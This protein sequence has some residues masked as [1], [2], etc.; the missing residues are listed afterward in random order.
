MS[1]YETFVNW[2]NDNDAILSNLSLETYK[3]S[4]R[5]IHSIN[6]IKRG[7]TLIE[8]PEKLLITDKMGEDTD[9]GR[10]IKKHS[11]Y[12]KNLKIIYVVLYILETKKDNHFFKPY[13]DIL[14]TSLSN[15]PIFWNKEDIILLTGSN[16]I[17]EI[18]IRQK[19]ITKDYEKI[20][21]LIPEFKNKY[22]IQTF[23]WARTIV[24][25]RN[26]GIV[27]DNVSRSA[28]VPICDLL[29]HDPNPDV[30]WGFN[31]RTR[32]FK[33]V[34]NRYLK[35]GKPI[36]DTYGIKSN[37]KYL[38][39][40]GFTIENNYKNDVIY[41]NLVHGNNNML[42]K[43]SIKKQV[44]GYL[45]TNINSTL[46]HDIMLFLR[47][48][49]SDNEILKNN[50]II[51]YYQ[52]PINIDNEKLAIKAFKKYLNTKLK[53]YKFFNVKSKNN[54]DKFSIK[55]NCCNLIMGEINIIL[56][57]LDY[58]NNIEGFLNGKSDLLNIK[59][60]IYRDMI[61]NII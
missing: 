61:K 29:N 19:E 46:F 31:Q 56:Y 58:L 2:C 9:Y 13:Y 37:L 44:T 10:I 53:N 30:T 25:S 17:N 35:K 21:E 43:N 34:S 15:F 6:G 23:I 26:F 28:M 4:E 11:K 45:S 32:S 12:F 57:Y 47:V 20:C 24:G 1:N 8:I 50:K 39:F 54:Y 48:A 41:I 7:R 18:I 52:K 27:I 36:T 3:N 42:F 59:E 14:P 49:V 51:S 60:S 55:W 33:M 22:S 38:L 5:G 40:Y 16:S